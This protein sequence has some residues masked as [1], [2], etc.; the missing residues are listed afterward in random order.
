MRKSDWVAAW[1]QGL[2]TDKCKVIHKG[3]NN[4]Y[5]SYTL[6]GSRLAVSTEKGALK[7]IVNIS[8]KASANSRSSQKRNWLLR[9]IRK[10]SE[11]KPENILGCAHLSNSV[12]SQSPQLRMDISG[13]SVETGMNIILY[14]PSEK[15]TSLHLGKREHRGEDK[16]E[17]LKMTGGVEQVSKE[18]F[19]LVSQ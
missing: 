9:I 3:K 5:Y 17:L 8:L 16:T 1:N 7:V 19:F 10:G 14:L 4:L 18:W 12:C 11:N 6:I 15:T 13:A 2:G